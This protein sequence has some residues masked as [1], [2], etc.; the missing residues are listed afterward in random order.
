MTQLEQLIAAIPSVY[1]ARD[2]SVS[3]IRAGAVGDE[4][5]R[6][7]LSVLA[8]PL[9][10]LEAAINQLLDD[11]FVERASPAALPLI[12][13]L[14]GAQLLTSDAGINRGVIART[15]GW[16]RRKGTLETLQEVLSVTSGWSC[17][18]DEAFRSLLHNQDLNHTVLR[19][20]RSAQLESPIVVSDPLSRR[21]RDERDAA[22]DADSFFEVRARLGRAD[23]GRYAASPRTVDLSG[24]ARPDAVVVRT[25]RLSAIAVD[26]LPVARELIRT[27]PRADG[28]TPE[29]SGF[30]LDPLGRPLPLIYKKP[31]DLP[32][33]VDLPPGRHEPEASSEATVPLIEGLLTPTALADDVA[34]IEASGSIEV[35]VD[36][37]ML[38]GASR[39]SDTIGPLAFAPLGPDPV[40]RLADQERPTVGDEWELELFAVDNPDSID[41]TI[42][43]PAAPSSDENPLVASVS[44]GRGALGPVAQ[45]EVSQVARGDAQVAL[46]VRRTDAAS[47]WR[48]AADGS[49]QT[50]A[51][52][53]SGRQPISPFAVVDDGGEVLALRLELSPSLVPRVMSLNLSTE[54]T[55]WVVAE[56]DLSG[57]PPDEQPDLETALDG[58]AVSIVAGSPGLFVVAERGDSGLLGVWRLNDPASASPSLTRID[59]PSLRVP[60]ARLAPSL[61]L[62]GERLFVFGGQDATSILSD[63]WSVQLNDT[64]SDFGLFRPHRVRNQQHRVLGQLLSTA[65]GLVL[66]GGA[67]TWGR[68]EPRVFSVDPDKPR[69]VWSE[70]APLPFDETRPGALWAAVEADGTLRVL[71]W[72]D[73]TC[74]RAYGLGLGANVWRSEP[75]EPDSSPNPP[76]FGSAFYLGDEFW[77]LDP[78]PLPPSEVILQVAGR[79]VLAFLPALELEV[80]ASQLFFVMADGST[81]QVGD[82]RASLGIGASR[83]ASS[84]GR[85]ADEQRVAAP[86]RLSF[87]PLRLMQASL[88]PWLEPFALDLEGRVALDARLGRVALPATLVS[89]TV[90]VSYW[91]GRPDEIG[92]GA[93][94]GDGKIPTQWLE[95][96]PGFGP[97]PFPGLETRER[98]TSRVSPN[99]VGQSNETPTFATLAESLADG[100]ASRRVT[101]D[102]SPRLASTPVA[103]GASDRLAIF[104]EDS[105]GYPHVEQDG[106]LSLVVHPRLGGGEPSS[107][108]NQQGGP[109]LFLGGISTEGALEWLMDSGTLDVRWASLATSGALGLRVVGALQ[110]STLMRR[111]LPDVRVTVRLYGCML[112]RI[113]LPPWAQLIAAGC[114]FD[115]GD[116]EL[117]AIAA[118]GARV[119]MR[120]CTIYGSTHAG[121]L[122]ASSCVFAGPVH[123]DRPDLGWLRHSVRPAGGRAPLSYR[124]I[125]HSVSFASISVTDPTYLVLS[126]NNP[127]EIFDLGERGFGVGAFSHRRQSLLELRERSRQFVPLGLESVH[128]DR[129]NIDLLRMRRSST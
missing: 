123:C 101:L 113:E 122:E 3:A 76:S 49:W 12:A 106:N 17:E 45:T 79:S 65:Q 4:P 126:D 44:Q 95:P 8:E 94:P 25:A 41:T 97:A 11:H 69:P 43:A 74:A 90:Q 96:D 109:E 60:V 116:R 55:T 42:E 50:L 63:M 5:L 51:I 121:A 118:P 125:E 6:A 107:D 67:S 56:L 18:V 62:H 9:D 89:G 36:G 1:W 117:A 23:A 92:A 32:Y 10:D 26:R 87:A 99:Q 104:P 98:A 61:C 119:R 85:A 73:S 71:A 24:W 102:R 14:V 2:H 115:S 86:H 75:P 110:Q 127:P 124:S 13:E 57:L 15:L 91:L 35:Y 103:L 70:L 84:G 81:Q 83:Q 58:P 16:R 48:R 33:S 20:G 128:S 27:I 22:P 64:E 46:R 34:G 66:V 82:Q 112:G 54:Q 120:H 108:A 100:A 28:Q 39:V 47:S 114:C 31:Q 78:P 30:S 77:V 59:G 80:G 19:R 53:P 40:L 37:I 93:L 105:A 129:V 38:V 7:L 68:L 29:Y 88:G 111:T 52:D 72:A 21:V